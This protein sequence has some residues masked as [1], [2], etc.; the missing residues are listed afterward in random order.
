MSGL[1]QGFGGI[2]L[3]GLVLNALPATAGEIADSLNEDR[4]IVDAILYR[5]GKRGYAVRTDR[6]RRRE[7]GKGRHPA[8]WERA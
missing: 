5:L 4:H 2:T 1:D 6:I 8:I 3:T 7:S